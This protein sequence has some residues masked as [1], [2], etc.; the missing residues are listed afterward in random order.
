MKEFL[1][2]R[3]ETLVIQLNQK[4]KVVESELQ[5]LENLCKELITLQNKLQSLEKV[6]E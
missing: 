2:K 3:I 4:K 5:N 6:N 1:I